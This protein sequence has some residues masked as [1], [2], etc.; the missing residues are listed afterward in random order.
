[1]FTSIL[2]FLSPYKLLIKGIALVL[3]VIALYA[4]YIHFKHGLI[5]IGE[6]NIQVKLDKYI[7]E[8]EALVLI[9][10][11]KNTVLRNEADKKLGFLAL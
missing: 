2:A 8:Q 11:A 1:M 9:A 3:F 7:K 5:A 10:N 4:Y 6:H